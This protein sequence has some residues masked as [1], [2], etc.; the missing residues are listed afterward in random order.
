MVDLH[1]RTTPAM[2]IRYG[3]APAPYA[4]WFLEWSRSNSG[5]V[6]ALVEVARALPIPIA[7]GE[8]LVTRWVPGAVREACLCASL[9]P[10]SATAAVSPS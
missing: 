7:T 9:N 1:G 4:P 2:A 8:R 3:H 6:D 5:N 10:T